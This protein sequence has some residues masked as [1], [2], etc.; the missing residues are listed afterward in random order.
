MK[1]KIA[2]LLAAMGAFL[3]PAMALA[4]VSVTSGP[5]F[6]NATQ[7]ITFGIGHGCEGADT[8][9]VKMVIPAGVLSVRPARS[10]FGKVSIEKNSAGDVTAITWQKTEADL[11]DGDISYYKLVVRMKVPNQPFTTLYFPTYQTC[12]ASDGTLSTTEW[13]GTGENAGEEPAPSLRVV[14]ARKP[15]WNK[16]TVPTA[17][18]NLNDFFGDAQI[19]WKGTA[20]FSSN[21][22]TTELIKTTSGVTELTEVLANDELW[23]K[24]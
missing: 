12:K 13:V 4:H 16:F 18:S 23:V 8:Y 15:G 14:P 20:A 2:T 17:L 5:G 6:A 22:T 9:S 21:S 11:L 3:A 24:Y 1:R 10:D 19:V 7:E